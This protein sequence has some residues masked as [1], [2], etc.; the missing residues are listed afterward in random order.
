MS[1]SHRPNHHSLS[2]LWLTTRFTLVLTALHGYS[3]LSRLFHLPHFCRGGESRAIETRPFEWNRRC[4]RAA[5]GKNGETRK[6]HRQLHYNGGNWGGSI[7]EVGPPWR[8]FYPQWRLKMAE[9][10]RFCGQRDRYQ[11]LIK[12]WWNIRRMIN[13]R[14]K[15]LWSFYERVSSLLT[16]RDWVDR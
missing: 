13:F 5:V 11:S 3:T 12:R 2:S 1:S 14:V 10:I 9:L 15:G 6:F 16:W 7:L 8:L 4:K